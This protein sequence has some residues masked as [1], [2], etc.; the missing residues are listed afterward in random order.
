MR[1][2]DVS[3]FAFALTILAAGGGQSQ[4]VLRG[5]GLPMST[6]VASGIR[7]HPRSSL[8]RPWQIL[9]DERLPVK[10]LGASFSGV[11]P[12]IDE[13]SRQ[14]QLRAE[15]KIAATQPISAIRVE[16]QL[17]DAWGEPLGTYH[18]DRI[19]DLPEGEHF[20]TADW[21][22]IPEGVS[23]GVYGTFAHVSRVRL[24]DGTIMTVGEDVVRGK[25]PEF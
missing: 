13:R 2:R 16:F 20:M 11:F 19:A 18:Y 12:R 23:S 4:E 22:A 17:F 6:E 24:T 9:N 21:L 25:A 3:A 14:Y 1:I 5:T 10:L 15:L 7:L 8:T